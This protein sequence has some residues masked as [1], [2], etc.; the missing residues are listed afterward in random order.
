M[1]FFPKRLLRAFKLL[2]ST[3]AL[4]ETNRAY[5]C[6]HRIGSG[7]VFVG[8]PSCWTR[9]HSQKHKPHVCSTPTV[10]MQ[11]CWGPVEGTCQKATA[12]EATPNSGIA[13]ELSRLGQPPAEVHPRA[14]TPPAR[15]RQEAVC[16][17]QL[18]PPTSQQGLYLCGLHKGNFS[19]ELI[20]IAFNSELLSGP[21]VRRFG[22]KALTI[23]K[24]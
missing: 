17:C 8:K 16:L 13:P 7:T 18:P 6:P 9:C 12:A 14:S 11:V 22:I 23:K 4:Q 24:G 5:V 19:P 20:I 21:S 2:T 10:C 3:A 15:R 1:G